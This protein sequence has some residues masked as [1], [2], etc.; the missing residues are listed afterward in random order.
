MI[1]KIEVEGGCSKP[2]VFSSDAFGINSARLGPARGTRRGCG[3]RL[4]DLQPIILSF[5]E[6]RNKFLAAVVLLERVSILVAFGAL[7]HNP[8]GNF[9]KRVPSLDDVQLHTRTRSVPLHAIVARGQRFSLDSDCFSE[10]QRFLVHTRR[11]RGHRQQQ[12]SDKQQCTKS[13]R[14]HRQAPYGRASTAASSKKCP[15]HDEAQRLF[16]S[17]SSMVP[18]KQTVSSRPPKAENICCSLDRTPKI[19]ECK[20]I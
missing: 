12:G 11:K 16:Y 17:I 1:L 5:E 2:L 7:G 10:M 13:R 3:A 6:N 4:R 18:G 9:K 20:A 14:F 19:S 15:P 8:C